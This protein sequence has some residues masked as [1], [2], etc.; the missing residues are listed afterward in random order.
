MTT[1]PWYRLQARAASGS[2]PA[3][4]HLY[5]FDVIGGG[6]FGVYPQALVEQIGAAKGQKLVAHINSPGGDA[7]AGIAL[8]NA[9][10]D[11][12]G[13][14]DVIVEGVAASAASLVAM[15]ALG[16]NKRV[17]MP[18]NARMMIHRPTGGVEGR[19]E[20]AQALKDALDHLEDAMAATYRAKTGL[21]DAV[22]KAMMQ[23][24]TYLTP[25]QA[26]AQ[27]FAD[28]IS[29]AIKVAAHFDLSAYGTVPAE[30][31]ATGE[32]DMSTAAN[33]DQ[34]QG[35]GQGTN[36]GGQATTQGQNGNQGQGGQSA[37]GQGDGSNVVNLEA[38]Q[39]GYSEA[40]DIIELCDLA[41]FGDRARGYLQ[42]NMT[43]AQVRT[44]LKTLRAQG[45]QG[46]G[47]TTQTQANG[48]QATTQGQGQDMRT[49]HG[50][51]GA[52]GQQPGVVKAEFKPGSLKANMVKM[53]EAQGMK[54]RV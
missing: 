49:T 22:L 34:G 17:I 46:G 45:V 30:L 33:G 44:E 8:C 47:Q 48:G 3:E 14:V 13:P 7:Y 15:G 38:R 25:E 29:P 32:T 1:G 40:A 2:A 50:N 53:V 31:L 54:P 10:R 24:T 51:G 23:S 4:T 39:A 5:I 16:A 21:P 43:A 52:T 41:G 20:D 37:Q 12:D 28:E 18:T 35:Q 11:H 27:G 6:F 36:N 9:L 26:K 42:A 19:S